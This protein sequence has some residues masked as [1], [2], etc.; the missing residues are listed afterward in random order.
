[1]LKDPAILILDEATSSVDSQTERAIQDALE[2]LTRGRTVVAIA[3]RL[4][5][6]LAADVILVFDHGRIVERGRHA[7]LLAMNGTYASLYRQQF[8]E[9]SPGVAAGG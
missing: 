5:T 6:I 2:R 8:A 3:H 9:E 4:S 7:E 1:L